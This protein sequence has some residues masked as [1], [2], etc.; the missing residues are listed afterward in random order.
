MSRRV[1]NTLEAMAPRVDVYSIDEAF[2]DLTGID[3][4]VTFE[5]FGAQ[6]KE[7]VYRHTG[8]PVCVGIAPTKTLAKLANR[9]AK[10]YP[11]TGGVV[12]LMAQARQ[13]KLMSLV[14]V[15][16]VWGVGAKISA[17]LNAGGI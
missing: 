9:G 17:K 12:N 11:A 16:D 8:M 13:R 10:K 15:E 1:M 14:A 2:L 6:V 3:R 4:V 5:Q 7:T